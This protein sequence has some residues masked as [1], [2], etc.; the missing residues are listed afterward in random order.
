M[1]SKFDFDSLDLTSKQRTALKTLLHEYADI[2][3]TGPADLG[4]TSVVKRQID[5]GDSPLIKQVLRRVP[6]DPQE[7]VHQHV[8]DMPQNGVE[9]PSPSPWASPIVLVK[10]KDG[11]TPFCVD[12]CKLN[13]V[14]RK[15]PYSLP[16]IDETLDALTGAKLF[17]TLQSQVMTFG[18]CK[19]SGT[20]KRLIE[21]VLSGL[22]WQT[23]LICLDDVIVFGWDFEEH[24]GQL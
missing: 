7:V 9:R 3:S 22:Q 21:F 16:R 24:L 19:T 17:S 8:K 14:A 23:C 4:I 1:S 15:D 18:L 12:Y 5:T 13:D 11:S 6:L 10:K 2:F 20:F